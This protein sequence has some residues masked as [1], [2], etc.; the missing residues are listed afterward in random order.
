M[1]GLFLWGTFCYDAIPLAQ[2]QLFGSNEM[3]PD[4][5]IAIWTAVGH[6]PVGKV[7]TYGQIARLAGFP[8]SARA[9]GRALAILPSDTRIPWHRVINA[10]G[11]ISFPIASEKFTEQA[12]RLTSEGILIKQGKISLTLFGW[13]L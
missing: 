10:K 6:I 13:E 7:A 8:N 9:V 2:L 3:Q 12:L 1:L 4:Y 5:N 11:Q